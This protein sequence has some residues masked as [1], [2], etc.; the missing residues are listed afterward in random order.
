MNT[1]MNVN[2]HSSDLMLALHLFL[3]YTAMKLHSYKKPVDMMIMSGRRDS[4]RLSLRGRRAVA[5]SEI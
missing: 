2:E 1:V 5:L 4:L 3:T